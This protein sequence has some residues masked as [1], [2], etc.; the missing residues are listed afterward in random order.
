VG[1]LTKEQT[2]ERARTYHIKVAEK[3]ESQ[4]ICFIP[5][6][7]YRRF[8]K[9]VMESSS[10]SAT[11]QRQTT[12]E[13][14]LTKGPIKDRHGHVIGEH[15]GFPFF[16]I[17]QRK[18]LG[19]AAGRPLYVTRID[20]DENAVYVGSE[21]ELYGNSLIATHLNW[22]SLEALGQ[23]QRLQAKIRYQHVPAWAALHPVSADQVAVHFDEP[24][25]AITPGQS[26]VFYDGERVVG[27][28]VIDVGTIPAFG[29]HRHLS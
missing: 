22:I 14:F 16:T 5:D 13:P 1:I 28:G 3:E 27:G 19:I 29:V 23:P 20:P 11:T 25:R 10:L 18:G 2:R 7:D 12:P 9:E 24:Q 15:P 8:L 4:E 6:N 26:V 21:E 17:G